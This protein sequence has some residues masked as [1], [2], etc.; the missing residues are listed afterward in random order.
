MYADALEDSNIAHVFALNRNHSG[1]SIEQRQQEALEQ[2]GRTEAAQNQKSTLWN[3]DFANAQTLGL[4]SE[5]IQQLQ[6]SVTH[7]IYNAWIV[8]CEYDLAASYGFGTDT[9]VCRSQSTWIWDRS[10]RRLLR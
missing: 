6:S 10:S 9:L 2:L 5:Q 8:N 3:V 7:V 4:S 1:K